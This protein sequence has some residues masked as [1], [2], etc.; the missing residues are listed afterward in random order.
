MSIVLDGPESHTFLPSK[1]VDEGP[2]LFAS[3]VKRGRRAKNETVASGDTQD[4]R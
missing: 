2:R 3:N 1:I 4:P